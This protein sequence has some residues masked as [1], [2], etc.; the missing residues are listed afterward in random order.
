MSA[1]GPLIV[2][3]RLGRIEAL[4]LALECVAAHANDQS[5]AAD[6]CGWLRIMAKD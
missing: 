1:P 4:T 5:A 3:A 2:E 6:A